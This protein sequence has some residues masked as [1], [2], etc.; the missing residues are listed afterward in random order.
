MVGLP[1]MGAAP[2]LQWWTIAGMPLPPGNQPRFVV[3]W[4]NASG[5]SPVATAAT[6]AVV[7]GQVANLTTLAVP[8]TPPIRADVVSDGTGAAFALGYS[9]Q[10][11]YGYWRGAAL[12]PFELAPALFGPC[13]DIS[14]DAFGSGVAIGCFYTSGN[15]LQWR[16]A[17]CP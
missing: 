12:D 14:I 4:G 10:T 9:N 7:N 3:A 6:F 16:A 2:N 15:P 8:G 13:I 11:R 17:G 1:F 5:G